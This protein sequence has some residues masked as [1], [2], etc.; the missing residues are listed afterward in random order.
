[1]RG[2]WV[3]VSPVPTLCTSLENTHTVSNVTLLEEATAAQME[4]KWGLYRTDFK[5]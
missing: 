3:R 1:M 4:V 5:C 2:V